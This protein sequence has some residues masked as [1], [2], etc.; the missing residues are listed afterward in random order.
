MV[1]LEK[2]EVESWG[3]GNPR[4]IFDLQVTVVCWGASFTL[5]SSSAPAA[6][7]KAFSSVPGAGWSGDL[8]ILKVPTCPTLWAGLS[9]LA[10]MQQLRDRFLH[11][12]F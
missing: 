12:S 1:G 10:S 8:E 7:S 5:S 11:S 2:N 6:L 3:G 4:L 9:L